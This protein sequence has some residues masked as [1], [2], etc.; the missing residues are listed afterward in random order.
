MTVCLSNTAQGTPFATGVDSFVYPQFIGYA[1]RTPTSQDVYNPGTRWQNNLN[2]PPSIY[3]T[4]GSGLWYYIAGPLPVLASVTHPDQ[5]P[6]NISASD[7]YIIVNSST[8]TTINLPSIPQ[9]GM[10]F[11]VKDGS[12]NSG[13]NPIV[14][15]GNGNT[16][17]SQESYIISN[18]YDFVG[19]LFDGFEWKVINQ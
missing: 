7:A 9:T 11:V 6:Y 4:T 16:V 12:G 19:V 3:E 10:R 1:L 8:D 17:D 15:D 14:V 2:Y 13:S 5:Y 18:N